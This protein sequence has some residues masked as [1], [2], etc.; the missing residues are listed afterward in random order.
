[1]VRAT[2]RRVSASV[3]TKYLTVE[4]LESAGFEALVEAAMRY[5]PDSAASFATFAHYRV[6]GAMIDAFRKRS[7]GHRAQQRALVRLTA[8]QALLQQAG[9]DQ[10][11]QRSAGHHAAL[12]Q[13]VESARALVSRAALAVC[14]AEPSE[15]YE[16]VATDQPDPEQLLLDADTRRRMWSLID[17]LD[18]HE[19]ALIHAIYERGRSMKDYAEEIGTSIATI[20]RRHARIV[21]L[22]GK[23][24]RASEWA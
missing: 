23:R 21:D 18:E 22:L 12:E 16:A 19:R 11:R 6:Y 1:L 3:G 8:T 17:Q 14:L 20:S 15:E 10:A 9:E 2:A 5:E 13:R 4:E 24:M 7:P